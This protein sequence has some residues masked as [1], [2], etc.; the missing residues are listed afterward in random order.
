MTDVYVGSALG[1]A[2]T[3]LWKVRQWLSKPP[4]RAAQ[5][6]LIAAG[7]EAEAQVRLGQWEAEEALP[8]LAGE[9][10]EALNEHATE[11]SAHIT[12]TL[13]FVDAG[14]RVLKSMVLKRQG[15]HAADDA[16]SGMLGPEEMN[17]QLT[18]DAR[19]QAQSAQRHLEVMCRVYM[20]GMAGLLAHSERLVTRQSEMLETLAS[21]LSRSER[22]ADSKE[23]EL[24]QLGEM[25]RQLKEDAGDRPNPVVERAWGL[26]EQLAPHILQ[27][28]M[29]RQQMP[30]NQ[31]TTRAEPV[32]VEAEQ[33]DE[34]DAA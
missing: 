18:G 19:S 23:M 11:M 16:A 1:S 26:M 27:Q 6:T 29:A 22:R 10:I 4:K 7:E 34:G 25:L 28:M 30:A 31:Q 5:L 2:N 13:A 21:R 14:G 24:Y 17:A 32:E 20:T 3:R 8:E 15:N 33:E 12:A 9:I